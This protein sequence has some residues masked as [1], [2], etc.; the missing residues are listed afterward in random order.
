[1]IMAAVLF[2]VVV[3]TTVF[4]AYEFY[5]Q[6]QGIVSEFTT[7]SKIIANQSQAAIT[8]G[9]T[10][11]LTEN[12][13]GLMLHRDV[14]ASCVYD[15]NFKL[16]A[17]LM[18]NKTVQPCPKAPALN[19]SLFD[20]QHYV[21]TEPIIVDNDFQGL[22]YIRVS[23][24]NLYQQ[25]TDYLIA[26]LA[27]AVLISVAVYYLSSALQTIIST[28]LL[29]LQHTASQVSK[30][31]DYSLQARKN[32]TD[33]IGDLVDAF[34]SMLAT[35]KAQ[36]D[37]IKEDAEL[38]EQ[39]IADRTRELA[40]VNNYLAISNKELDV[41]NK[42]L[43]AFSYSVSHDLRSPLRAIDGFTKALLEDYG[44]ELDQ[45]A[46]SYMKRTRDASQ[47][48]GDLINTLLQLSRV[49]RKD[50]VPVKINISTLCQ[51]IVDELKSRQPDRHIE[52]EIDPVMTVYA[53]AKLL[54][55]ALDNLIGNAWKYTGY[56]ARPRIEI[57]SYQQQGKTV[58]YVKDNGA[59][60][61]KRYAKDLF[62]A[63]KRLH[64]TDQFEGTGIGLATVSRIIHRH[65]GHIWATSTLNEGASFY[66]TLNE[67]SPE[68]IESD[69]F[70]GHTHNAEA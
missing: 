61:D 34:N 24:D 62:S 51:N 38:L 35:I 68:D 22:L 56:E 55:V 52:V 64:A 32:S 2:A 48:M 11:T 47:K 5:N 49:S 53:D 39:K 27:L 13:D 19:L 4:I 57:G 17:S 60:F 43:E 65:H 46:H 40:D 18:R 63:F 41:A 3:L 14:I 70:Y 21:R 37:K 42:E 16:L 1:M 31:Q 45:V 59:G 44:D 67:S 58:Y 9:D 50:L 25:Q 69:A 29:E 28:P 26:M 30:T 33:E 20:T 12:L 10:A 8:F 6:K 66:F 15:A 23:L 54:E 7:T 36:N